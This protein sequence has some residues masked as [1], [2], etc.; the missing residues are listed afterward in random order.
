MS[1]PG[2]LYKLQQFDI[3]LQRSHQ[4]AG[5]IAHQLNENGALVA[6]ESELGSQKQQLAK[7]Q[8]KTEEC[9]MGA[10]RPAR[11]A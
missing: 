3:E 11:K 10:R 7:W 1:L 4:L 8:K 9:R 6:T 2:Q 5:E